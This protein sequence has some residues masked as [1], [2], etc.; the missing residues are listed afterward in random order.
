V[1]EEIILLKQCI[2]LHTYIHKQI[3]QNIILS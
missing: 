1:K 3:D 2:N